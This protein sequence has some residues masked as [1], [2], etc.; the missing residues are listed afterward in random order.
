MTVRTEVIGVGGCA[1]GPPSTSTTE[2][3]AALLS[4]L[5]TAS[6]FKIALGSD[7]P[8]SESDSSKSNDSG[9]YLIWKTQLEALK[10]RIQRTRLEYEGKMFGEG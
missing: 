6:R 1:S 3:E 8:K 10:L 2:Y 5:G 4:L 7:E 9:R